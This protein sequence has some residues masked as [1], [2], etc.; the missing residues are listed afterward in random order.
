[1]KQPY[2][3]HAR[4]GPRSDEASR[5]ATIYQFYYQPLLMIGFLLCSWWT[6][7]TG[8]LAMAEFMSGISDHLSRIAFLVTASAMGAQFV[9]WHYAMRLIPR[10]ATHTARGIGVLVLLILMVMLALSSTHTSFIGLTQDSARGL[11]LQRQSDLYADKAR[12]LAPRANAMEDALLQVAPAA[13]AACT[14]YEQELTSGVI[15]GSRGRGIVTGHFLRLCET[16]R[17]IVEALEETIAA[18]VLRMNEIQ[19]LSAQLDRI[20]YDRRRT[21]GERELEFIDLARRMDALLL[22]L[23]NA[24]RTRGL[25][26]SAQTMANSIGELED[27]GTTLGAAQAQAIAAVILEERAAAGSINTLIDEIEALPR[28]VPG[29]AVIKPS[30]TL[31]LEHWKLHLP[32]LAISACIDLFAPLSTLLFWAAAIRAR[33][34]NP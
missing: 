19:A 18:N 16:K 25:R 32:Q 27:T 10:Y 6:S 5:F 23:E 13:A 21:I 14:R 17:S 1:M 31:V 30:Q 3:D 15:T 29:R 11:E 34:R 8:V 26:A 12:I 9:L 20:I 22:E 4:W 2:E 28:P 33:R 24:D 7:Y